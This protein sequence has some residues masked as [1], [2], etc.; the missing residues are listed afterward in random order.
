MVLSEFE[1]IHHAMCPNRMDPIKFS[2]VQG[3]VRRRTMEQKSSPKSFVV[4]ALAL[5]EKML[6]SIEA[7]SNILATY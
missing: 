3:G 5:K 2:S 7:S 4:L 6:K 1:R